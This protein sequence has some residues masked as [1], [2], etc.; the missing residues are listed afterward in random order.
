MALKLPETTLAQIRENLKLVGEQIDTSIVNQNNDLQVKED[1]RQKIWSENI[2]DKTKTDLKSDEKARFLSISKIFVKEWLNQIKKFQAAQE[3]KDKLTGEEP[4]AKKKQKI[5][6]EFLSN[7]VKDKKKKVLPEKPKE[8]KSWM[9]K[10]FK[11]VGLLTLGW[12]MFKAFLGKIPSAV[13]DSLK[14]VGK[15]ILDFV[16]NLFGMLWDGITSDLGKLWDWIKGALGLDAIGNFFTSAWDT[17]SGWLSSLWNGI[18]SVWKS[19]TGFIV[20]LPKTIWNWICDTAKAIFDPIID[21]ISAGWNW[22]KKVVVG[23]WDWISE[24]LS[25]FWNGLKK[26]WQSVVNFFSGIWD[27]IKETFSFSNIWNTVKDWFNNKIN[28]YKQ[29]FRLLFEGNWKEFALQLIG[30]AINIL[31]FGLGGLAQK[32]IKA[33]VNKFRK[34]EEVGTTTTVTKP[35]VKKIIEKQEDIVL[36]DNVL[37]TVKEICD[38]INTFFSGRTNGFIDLSERLLS[39]TGSGFVDMINKL[40]EVELKNV[41]NYSPNV[42]HNEQDHRIDQSTKTFNNDFSTMNDYSINFNTID[43]PSLNQ[44]IDTLSRQS[45]AEIKLLRSQNDYLMKM[46]GSIDKFDASLS[47]LHKE[48]YKPK[49]QNTIIPIFGN[50]AKSGVPIIDNTHL[51]SAQNNNAQAFV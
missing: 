27:W 32:G 30:K 34:K 13:W 5:P 31:T 44:A 47:W 19:V 18:K 11:F 14:N 48:D 8:K 49:P 22:I 2:I 38:R 51:I 24:Q 9:S 33:L 36:K 39:A 17:V 21:A 35:D 41:Y 45:E 1:N 7:L 42:Y 26:T 40:K 12:V 6:Y 16:G 28:E 3:K 20:D 25:S 15:D 43:V 46:I 37:E 4:V 10:I 50:L 29:M 23:V